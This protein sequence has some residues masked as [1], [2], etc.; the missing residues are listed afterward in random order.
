[1]F[2]EEQDLVYRSDDGSATP[3]SRPTEP[4]GPQTTPWVSHPQVDSALLFR[5][6]ALTANAH[7][8]HYDEPYA[9]GVEG[10]PGLVVHGP[11][12]AV[13]LA[14]LARRNGPTSGLSGFEFQLRRPVFVGDEFRVQGTPAGDGKSA[15]LTVVSGAATTHVTAT[16]RYA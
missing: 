15:S 1:V 11:L 8:I 16:A 3:F 5:F 9:T 6:S 14:E 2:V 12:L 7:R 4:L 10:F 13:Y